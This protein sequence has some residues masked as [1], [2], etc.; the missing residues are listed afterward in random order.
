MFRASNVLHEG[1]EHQKNRN[2]L[3]SANDDKYFEDYD[4]DRPSRKLFKSFKQIDEGEEDAETNGADEKKGDALPVGDIHKIPLRLRMYFDLQMKA[5][6][7]KKLFVIRKFLQY[8]IYGFYIAFVVVACLNEIEI[9]STA[10]EWAVFAAWT[11]LIALNSISFVVL[12]G[13]QHFAWH[14]YPVLFQHA[15][16]LVIIALLLYW[17]LQR[18]SNTA[19]TAQ[20]I[21]LVVMGI[22]MFIK[23]MLVQPISKELRNFYCGAATTESLI[24]I[25]EEFKAGKVVCEEAYSD[26]ELIQSFELARKVLGISEEV[27][28]RKVLE[29]QHLRSEPVGRGYDWAFTVQKLLKHVSFAPGFCRSK[30]KMSSQQCRNLIRQV[31]VFDEMYRKTG[32]INENAFDERTLPFTVPETFMAMLQLSCSIPWAFVNAIIPLVLTGF[33]PIYIGATFLASF[34]EQMSAQCSCVGAAI[35]DVCPP[36]IMD[37]LSNFQTA[38][39]CRQANRQS[40]TVSFWVL[41][42]TLNLGM[43]I[44]LFWL[45]IAMSNFIATLGDHCRRKMFAGLTRGGTEYGEIHQ[46]G[47]LIDAFSNQLA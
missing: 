44:V 36:I 43:P 34:N 47:K 2:S 12:G 9:T 29:G 28:I 32:K 6:W 11:V 39:L 3:F 21:V 31:L 20:Y 37:T 13:W 18:Q 38:E 23:E 22:Y 26:E 24:D 8:A 14:G 40:A 45:S 7:D 15:C 17:R 10:V 30:T 19:E 4:G 35:S 33:I 42:L 25:V 16:E 5:Q 1:L 41:V 27:P 46:D